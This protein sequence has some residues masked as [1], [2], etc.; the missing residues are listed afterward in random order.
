MAGPAALL[1]RSAATPG[2]PPRPSG[3][4]RCRQGE[5][6][7][8]SAFF[9]LTSVKLTLPESLRMLLCCP[10]SLEFCIDK[11]GFA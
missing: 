4:R 8:G 2:S 5:I 6:F 9:G 10:A 7:L 1:L 3:S 11:P